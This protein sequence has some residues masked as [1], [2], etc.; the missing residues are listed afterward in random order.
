MKNTFSR[1]LFVLAIG[2]LYLFISKN[3]FGENISEEN[4]QKIA[5]EVVEKTEEINQPPKLD[6]S[7]FEN[8][9]PDE[10][11]QNIILMPQDYSFPNF[12]ITAQGVAKESKLLKVD[13]KLKSATLNISASANRHS[14]VYFY[15]DA[16]SKGG[17]IDATRNEN[18][19]RI[20]S[21]GFKYQEDY[22]KSFDL[23]SLNVSNKPQG[24]IKIPVLDIL[25]D[26]KW[27]HFIGFVNSE[28]G[29][30]KEFSIDYECESVCEIKIKNP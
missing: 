1:F 27:H 26:N 24:N 11:D 17:L 6:L 2:V 21:G 18:E 9:F 12:P 8:E 7:E 23:K 25:N 29:I 5:K 28:G 20:V 30:L 14:A 16:G 13:G 22:E 3:Y 10:T 4:I 19:S 15:I